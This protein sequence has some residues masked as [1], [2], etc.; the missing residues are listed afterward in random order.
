MSACGE[1]TAKLQLGQRLLGKRLLE[2]L[3]DLEDLD[4]VVLADGVHHGVA[5]VFFYAYTTVATEAT[6]SAKGGRGGRGGTSS[7]TAVRVQAGEGGQLGQQLGQLGMGSIMRDLSR[8][9]SA[10]VTVTCRSTDR[11]VAEEL[12]RVVQS[13]LLQ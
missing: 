7:A 9:A 6:T 2:H 12:A 13:A 8:S 10:E 3:E 1:V 11:S 4:V 5:K